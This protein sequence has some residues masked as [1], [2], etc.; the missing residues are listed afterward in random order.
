LPWLPLLSSKFSHFQKPHQDV[1]GLQGFAF[2][3]VFRKVRR[4]APGVAKHDMSG[5]LLRKFGVGTQ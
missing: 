3:P 5:F 2:A 1:A 4:V